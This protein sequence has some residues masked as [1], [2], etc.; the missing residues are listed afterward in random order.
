MSANLKFHAEGKVGSIARLFAIP[1]VC[2]AAFA[3]L[4]PSPAK[5]GCLEWNLNGYWEFQLKTG[6]WIGFNLTQARWKP[7]SNH[8]DL[9]GKATYNTP[10]RADGY[11]GLVVRVVQGGVD[12]NKFHLIYSVDEPGLGEEHPVEFHG[13]IDPDGNLSGM[14]PTDLDR[15]KGTIKFHEKAGRKAACQKT[16]AEAEVQQNPEGNIGESLKDTQPP[17]PEV[18]AGVFEQKPH[19]GIGDVLKETKP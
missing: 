16:S 13:V 18:K 19:K 5:G 11:G 17:T 12:G 15:P 7:N 9:S 10:R 6:A 1:T 3:A 4:A 2:A 14:G 8:F